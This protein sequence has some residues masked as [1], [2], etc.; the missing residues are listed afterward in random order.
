MLVD[1]FL[2]SK[3][4]STPVVDAS[5]D[6][7]GMV[8]LDDYHKAKRRGKISPQLRVIDIAVRPPVVAYPEES[9]RHALMRMV[10]R[11]LSRL[12]VVGKGDRRKLLGIVGSHDILRAYDLGVAA[13]N[14]SA[15]EA[16]PRPPGTAPA[17]FKVV[18]GAP[19]D[20]RLLK[21]ID[22][23]RE[24]V[25]VGIVRDGDTIIP[26]GDTE[27]QQGDRVMVLMAEC[28]REEIRSLFGEAIEQA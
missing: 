27:L 26:H 28:D 22:L 15:A 9:V 7:V 1:V 23:P 8:S 6:L 21:E 18:K 17:A 2:K 3:R 16:M 14:G 5:G 4:R 10:P 13:Q 20:A 12:P 19:A 24:C 11:D 25:V